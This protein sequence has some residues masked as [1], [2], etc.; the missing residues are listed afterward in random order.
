MVRNMGVFFV[1]I[2]CICGC[3]NGSEV[4]QEQGLQDT[5]RYANFIMNVAMNNC[6]YLVPDYAREP[7]LIF[8]DN[9][10]YVYKK[11]KITRRFFKRDSINGFTGCKEIT[12]KE[13]NL[14]LRIHRWTCGCEV[15]LPNT[16]VYITNQKDFEYAFVLT[17]E[18]KVRTND[19][20][21]EKLHPVGPPTLQFQLNFISNALK[22]NTLQ[23]TQYAE[24][25]FTL[26]ADSLLGLKRLS[27]KDITELQKEKGAYHTENIKQTDCAICTQVIDNQMDKM[28]GEIKSGNDAVLYCRSSSKYYPGFWKFEFIVKTGRIFINATFNKCICGKLHEG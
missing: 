15:S 26:V 27:A 23:S 12:D 14:T 18:S 17:D 7:E 24:H 8:A 3:N 19:T 4:S 28:L 2:L 25:F 11:T 10:Y 5:V 6:N 13:L 9:S 1:A 20:V 22:I 16:I 21:I